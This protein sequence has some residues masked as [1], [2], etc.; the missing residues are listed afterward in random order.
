VAFA[1]VEQAWGGAS[2]VDADGRPHARARPSGQKLG[3][4]TRGRRVSP[5]GCALRR[6]LSWSAWVQRHATRSAMA[7]S[8]IRA[9]AQLRTAS[10]AARVNRLS[11]Y[12]T[13]N[14]NVYRSN[15]HLR[16]RQ[17]R[18]SD[19]HSPVGGARATTGRAEATRSA[20]LHGSTLQP[21]TIWRQPSS[22]LAMGCPAPGTLASA[23]R[24]API[25]PPVR[26]ATAP[27]SRLPGTACW[28][29]AGHSGGGLLG[30]GQC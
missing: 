21:V 29:G 11:W 7:V 1:W 12:I 26:R 25:R 6:S 9:L 2:A 16:V 24:R 10:S 15:S 20:R 18:T 8:G 14:R 17:H 13:P 27:G 30:S 4:V 5:S 3:S 28:A 23:V 19:L 22:R